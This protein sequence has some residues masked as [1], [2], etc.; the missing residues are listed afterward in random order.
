LYIGIVLFVV[1]LAS[2]ELISFSQRRGTCFL[3]SAASGQ[4]GTWLHRQ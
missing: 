3:Q 4:S 1:V 2:Y